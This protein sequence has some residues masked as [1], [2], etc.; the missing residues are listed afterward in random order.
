MPLCHQEGSAVWWKHSW[1]QF[2]QAFLGTGDK[3]GQLGHAE[4]VI[5]QKTGDR[6]I[7]NQYPLKNKVQLIVFLL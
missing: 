1:G 2:I 6:N 3:G 4:A 5:A 7:W